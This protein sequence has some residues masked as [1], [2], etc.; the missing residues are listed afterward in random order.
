MIDAAPT[1]RRMWTLY[2]PVHVVTYFAPAAL[3][4][5]AQAGLRGFWRGYFA[6]RA[7]PIG[8]VGAAPVTADADQLAGVAAG[9]GIAGRTLGEHCGD[10]H[11]AALVAADLDA[12]EAGRHLHAS[13]EAAARPWAGLDGGATEQLAAALLPVARACAAVLPAGNPVGVPVPAGG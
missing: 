3:Q 12:P 13:I 7:A 5:F 10:G 6:G 9:L 4:A 8:P 1:A 2:E 11:I